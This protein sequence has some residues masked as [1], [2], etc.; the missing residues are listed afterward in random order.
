ML[1]CAE[2]TVG[3][4]ARGGLVNPGLQPVVVPSMCNVIE[5][6]LI[7]V[8]ARRDLGRIYDN[9]P[10]AFSCLLKVD[11]L[12]CHR[13]GIEIVQATTL[14]DGVYILLLEDYGKN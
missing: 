7:G 8:E 14:E 5:E 9:L 6:G 2:S 12:F 1:P 10:L 13:H 11:K 4:R 3:G